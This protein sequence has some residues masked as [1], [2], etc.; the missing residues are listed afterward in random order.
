MPKKKDKPTPIRAKLKDTVKRLESKGLI[1]SEAEIKAWEQNQKLMQTAINE[2]KAHIVKKTHEPEQLLFSFMPTQMTRTTP[3][4]PMSKREMKDRPVEDLTWETSWGQITV[5]GERLAV[6][7]ETTL[8]NLL[9]LVKKHRSEVFETT[10]YE[11]C[12]LANVKPATDTYN[13]I[14]KSI[15]RL[16][17]T[18]IGLEIWE[19]KGRAR[20]PVSEMTG[21]IITWIRRNRKTGKLQV[22]LN[23]YFLEMYG[24]SF[25]T[26]IDL[27]F[28]ADLKGD[29]GKALYRFYEG[30]RGTRY[31]IHILK[32]ATA[33]NLNINLST[34]EL[35]KTIRKGLRELRA[36]GYLERWTLPPKSDLVT[37]WKVK[38][39]LLNN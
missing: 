7:D 20:K 12:K 15:K 21:T 27:K 6:Y 22:A 5:S 37:V 39:K 11:L 29:T 33:I 26:N 23:P 30:Q 1:K 16:S 38:K 32:L 34:N 36:K 8:L 35:R 17:K 25:I 9:V 13:A 24:D 3:F 2:T 4:Y 31:T 14:W 18:H 28:R 19:G 10:Q